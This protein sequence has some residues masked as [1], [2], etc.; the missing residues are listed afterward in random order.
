[1][2]NFDK[3]VNNIVSRPYVS[4]VILTFAILYG[5]ELRPKGSQ[6]PW[7][8]QSVVD[9]YAVKI[10]LVWLLLTVNSA[11]PFYSAIITAVFFA[12]LYFFGGS[13]GGD[14]AVVENFKISPAQIHKGCEG[15]KMD[16]L[17]NVFNGDIKTLQVQMEMMNV[18]KN[19]PL[20]DEYAPLIAT[21]LINGGFSISST[22]K[23]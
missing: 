10:V 18:P 13:D 9:A 21:H 7:Q 20:T 8:V 5:T 23:I 14:A 11:Q 3:I 19:I 6:L 15:V 1:M 16:D 4:S 22:C 12:A 2:D 17:K